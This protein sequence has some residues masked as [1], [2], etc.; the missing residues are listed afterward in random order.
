LIYY[1]LN[2]KKEKEL[3]DEPIAIDSSSLFGGGI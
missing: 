3:E 1:N 2:M